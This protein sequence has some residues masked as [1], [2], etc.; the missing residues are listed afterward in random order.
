MD[1]TYET[2]HKWFWAWQD[3]KEEAWLSE[4]ARE[5]LHLETVSLGSYKFRKGEPANYVYRLDY[6]A[7]RSK[8]KESY[9]QIFEDAGWELVGEM[10]GWVYFRIKAGTGESPEI[11]NDAESKMGKYQR[12]IM[13]LVIFLPIMMILR[14]SG[15][16]QYG[17]FSIIVEAL[18]ALLFL[19]Y[20][21]AMVQLFRRMNQLKR[22]KV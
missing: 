1:T 13:Y 4:K 16:D 22:K 19:L 2:K 5:G 7:F 15:V 20:T 11:F 18:F 14:P 12:V 9:L 8:E 21:F 6:Q 10:S 17:T 3:E